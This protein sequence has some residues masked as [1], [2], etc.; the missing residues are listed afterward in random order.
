MRGGHKGGSVKDKT[1]HLRGEGD[2]NVKAVIPCAQGG[3]NCQDSNTLS[4]HP[5]A[6]DRNSGLHQTRGKR[7]LCLPGAKQN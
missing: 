3:K 1:C 2:V 4:P 7:K 5:P 6:T